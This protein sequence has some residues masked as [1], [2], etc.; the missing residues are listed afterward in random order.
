MKTANE[1]GGRDQSKLSS[2][3][4]SPVACVSPAFAFSFVFSSSPCAIKT[5][6]RHG[7]AFFIQ[8]LQQFSM[9]VL[10]RAWSSAI[11]SRTA[12]ISLSTKDGIMRRNYQKIVRK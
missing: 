4:H 6:Q 2:E 9:I 3:E 8:K 1:V 12:L 5:E 11:F 10:T 7:K